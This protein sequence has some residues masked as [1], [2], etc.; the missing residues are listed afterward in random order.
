MKTIPDS[1]VIIDV[2]RADPKWGV[3]SKAQLRAGHDLVTNPIVFAESASQVSHIKSLEVF[4]NGIGC[5]LESLPWEAAFVA[6]HAHRDY[7]KRGGLKARV[8]PDFLIGAHAA[9]K[10]YRILTRDPSRYRTYFPNVEI[11]APETAA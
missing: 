4:F 2:L 3:W 5:A 7:R 10:S 11:I 6:G 8:L 1:N 9:V